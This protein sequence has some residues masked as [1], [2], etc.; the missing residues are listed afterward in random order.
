[1]RTGWRNGATAR[2]NGFGTF[3]GPDCTQNITEEAAR[4]GW[5]MDRRNKS[6]ER[7]FLHWLIA[8]IA[9]HWLI[10]HRHRR[11]FLLLGVSCTHGT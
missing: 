5:A 4:G 11:L 2:R 10:V 1:M 6:T 3:D 9:S 8:R 7:L